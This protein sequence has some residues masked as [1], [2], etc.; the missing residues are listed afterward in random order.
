M[1]FSYSIA[2]T[3]FSTFLSNKKCLLILFHYILEV[4]DFLRIPIKDSL[5]F[6]PTTK[7]PN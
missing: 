4:S 7:N 6:Y 2:F 1:S 3:F 5:H